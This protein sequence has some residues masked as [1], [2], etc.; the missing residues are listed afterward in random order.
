[1]GQ[2]DWRKFELLVSAIEE[3]LAPKGAT[4]KS[5]DRLPDLATGGWRDVDATIRL[6]VGSTEILIAVECRKRKGPADVTWIEQLA[7]KQKS[8]GADKVIAV[9]AA[10]FTKPAR[11]SAHRQGIE[12]RVLEE[13]TSDVIDGWIAPEPL[14]HAYCVVEALRCRVLLRSGDEIELDEMEPRFRHPMVSGDFP[15]VAFISFMEMKDPEVIWGASQKQSGELTF[16]LNARDPDLIPV[17]LGVPRKAGELE[18]LVDDIP[19]LVESV[20]LTLRADRKAQVIPSERGQHYAYG[21]PDTPS[22]TM[23][24]FEGEI[25]G[26]P[27]RIERFSQPDGP[28]SAVAA[29]PN[30]LRLPSHVLKPHITDMSTVDLDVLHGRPVSLRVRRTATPEGEEFGPLTVDGILFRPL[31]SFFESVEARDSFNKSYFMFLMHADV[32]EIRRAADEGADTKRFWDLVNIFP[33][34]AIEY[35]DLTPLIAAIT[36]KGGPKS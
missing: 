25:A 17:P 8:I 9:S 4:V 34:D 13:I 16:N 29:F 15:P 30:G 2:P 26:V 11:A 7:T 10:G 24:Q 28:P 31:E 3:R 12:L 19:R 33:H 23:S 32:D 20:V 35:I 1:M 14:V 18:V 21:P 5:P 27:V 36:D 22:T 6:S